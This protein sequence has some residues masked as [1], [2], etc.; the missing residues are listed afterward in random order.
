M[1]LMPTKDERLKYAEAEV[2]RLNK[3]ID[4]LMQASNYYQPYVNLY[5]LVKNH[6]NDTEM[7]R[8][9]LQEFYIQLQKS[10]ERIDAHIKSYNQ[11]LQTQ[12]DNIFTENK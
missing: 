12:V 10:V 5:A 7:S 1:S 6:I 2:S 4:L 3:F 11:V 8:T 9:K